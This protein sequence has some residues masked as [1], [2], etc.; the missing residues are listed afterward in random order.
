[1]N[2]CS[3]L[4]SCVCAGVEYMAQYKFDLKFVYAEF[5]HFGYAPN[6][7]VGVPLGSREC[8]SVCQCS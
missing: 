1:M 4:G 8:A 5:G 3:A 6:S 2:E 7:C